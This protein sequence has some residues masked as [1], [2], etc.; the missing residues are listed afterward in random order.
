MIIEC[1]SMLESS[2][3]FVDSIDFL[4]EDYFPKLEEYS[5]NTEPSKILSSEVHDIES[6]KFELQ[7][8]CKNYID[9]DGLLFII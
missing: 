7:N 2:Y 4:K 5:Q 1:K 8:D 3:S 9:E 6:S